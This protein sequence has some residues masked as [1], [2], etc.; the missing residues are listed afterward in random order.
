MTSGGG[1]LPLQFM[2]VCL[3]RL[4][5][6]LLQRFAYL[7]VLSL[8]INDLRDFVYSG[9]KSSDRYVN[10][11]YFIVVCPLLLLDS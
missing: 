6:C 5:T 10:C 3:L 9:Y 8:F 11:K 2:A 1:H 4:L 7:V